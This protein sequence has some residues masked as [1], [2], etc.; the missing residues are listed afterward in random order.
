MRLKTLRLKYFKSFRDGNIVFNS[1]INVILGPNGSG[2]SN[3]CDGLKFVLGERSLNNLRAKS[4][5]DLIYQGAQ[6]AHVEAV[7]DDN[8]NEIVLER[9]IRDDKNIYYINSKRLTYE[10]YINEL[11]KLQL[12]NSYRFFIMQGQVERI[13]GL[14]KKERL[15]LLYDGAGVNQFE[16]RKEEVIENI[17][18]VDQKISQLSLVVG[19]KIKYLEE[20]KTEMERV[21]RYREIQNRI[22]V[23]RNS[24]MYRE[25]SSR[26]RT[27]ENLKNKMDEIMN[28]QEEM[29]RKAE[30]L[31]GKIDEIN[32]ERERITEELTS[33]QSSKALIELTEQ[34][35]ALEKKR[36]EL[37]SYQRILFERNKMYNSMLSKR[38]ELVSAIEALKSKVKNVDVDDIQKYLDELKIINTEKNTIESELANIMVKYREFTDLRSNIDELNRL[39]EEQARLS[40]EIVESYRRDNEL[41][42]MLKEIDEELR[43]LEREK[44]TYQFQSNIS[45]LDTFVKDLK[46]N[47]EGVYDL[48]INLISFDPKLRNA[49]DAFGVRLLNIVVQDIEVAKRLR[50][51]IKNTGLRLGRISIIPLDQLNVQSYRNVNIGLGLLKTHVQIDRGLERVL[52]YVFGDVV[53]VN[54]FDEAKKYIGK[55]RMVTL[56]GEFFDMTGVVSIGYQG[57][58]VSAARVYAEIVKRIEELRTKKENVVAERERILSKISEMREKKAHVDS[59]INL[60]SVNIS[61]RDLESMRDTIER[62]QRRKEELTRRGAEIEEMLGRYKERVKHAEEVAAYR[63]ELELRSQEL[64]NLDRGIAELDAEIK[65]LNLKIRQMSDEVRIAELSVAQKRRK[66]MEIDAKAKEKLE[67]S[68]AKEEELKQLGIELQRVS[69]ELA[70]ME[71]LYYRYEKERSNIEVEL[72]NIS[73]RQDI[74]VIEGNV[75]SMK[76][77]LM[78]LEAELAT[79]GNMNFKAK[80][81]YE[82]LS[83][84]IG[85]LDQKISKLRQ[86]K[87][88]LINIINELEAKK[89]IH[90][91]EFISRVNA[92]F[93]E[94]TQTIPGFGRA[95]IEYTGDD[96]IISLTRDGKKVRLESLS[97][98]ERSLLGLLLIFAMN[99]ENP[100]PIAVFDEV[101]AALDRMNKE[102]LKE[103]IKIHSERTQ[104][105]IV[106]HSQDVA[107]VGKNIIGVSKSKDGSKLAQISL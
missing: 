20:L 25:Y 103:F 62:L 48:V 46:G 43:R 82:M 36:E 29:K 1:D 27:L 42:K 40:R 47:V 71:R 37:M 66:Y 63:R 96:V 17:R 51:I 61:D 15:Q 105:I 80:E 84:D 60:M 10:E 39:K 106:T 97:G 70:Q 58:S 2:K 4:S 72:R 55:Y 3:I 5:R 68:K 56:D 78:K 95:D 89:E 76:E 88:E 32:R 86:E 6:E 26:I 30:E 24:I 102:R 9:I 23:L 18:E 45:A 101:D 104:F 19:E 79:F 8:G 49:I 14:S 31:R 41:S 22:D 38:Q 75:D 59:R 107:R 12:G 54:D 33:G 77:E 7:L 69:E 67:I 94:L 50:D 65:E 11:S 100:L 74:P 13:I 81:M 90:F 35:Q 99:Q 57:S 28:R 85:E 98:G 83:V 44:D 93:G 53:L 87:E 34:Q 64:E 92:R 21:E 73:Y 16:N 91:R 52:D